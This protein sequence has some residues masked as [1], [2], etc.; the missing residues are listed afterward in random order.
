MLDSGDS[1]IAA[2]AIF[3]SPSATTPTRVLLYNSAFFDGSG[4]RENMS[5]SLTGITG[6]TNVSVKRLTASN[7]NVQMGVTIGGG[8]SFAGSCESTGTQSLESILV[9]GGKAIVSVAESQAVIVFL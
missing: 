4:T 7:A 2:Y 8:G 3:N 1:A 6:L 9:N 5:I